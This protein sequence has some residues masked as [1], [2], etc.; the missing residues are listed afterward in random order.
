MHDMGEWG[1]AP[2]VTPER[3]CYVQLLHRIHDP[4]TLRLALYDMLRAPE[5]DVERLIF[6]AE[7]LAN[8]GVL[9]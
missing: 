2:C 7:M 1:E 5:E 6:E 9:Y 8:Y 4:E 3:F